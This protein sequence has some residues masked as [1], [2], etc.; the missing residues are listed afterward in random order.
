M[1]VYYSGLAGL[2]SDLAGILVSRVLSSRPRR[3]SFVSLYKSRLFVRN[4]SRWGGACAGGLLGRSR[5]TATLATNLVTCYSLPC[6]KATGADAPRGRSSR[7]PPFVSC[8]RAT[9]RADWCARDLRRRVSCRGCGWRWVWWCSQSCILLGPQH[10][11]PAPRSIP[12]G[13]EKWFAEHA[14][15]AIIEN[16]RR[17]C[18]A[19]K[20]EGGSQNRPYSDT[21]RSGLLRR[22]YGRDLLA[23]GERV[24]A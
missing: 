17:R 9:K 10:R 15:A 5:A 16:R 18:Q 24:G 2:S 21:S 13:R 23:H 19:K 3:N 1:Y 14:T 12:E 22:K 8:V 20:G 7:Q 11:G 4:H 6:L